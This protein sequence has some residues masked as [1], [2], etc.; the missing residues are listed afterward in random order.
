MIATASCA[1][2]GL[3]NLAS[4]DENLKILHFKANVGS[5][6]LLRGEK[7]ANGVLDF[8]FTGTVL[9]SGAAANAVT[10]TGDVKLEYTNVKYKKQVF[11]GSGHMHLVGE[12]DNVQFFGRSVEGVFNGLG[13]MR[14]YGEFDK[15]LNTGSFW[16]EGG[17]H[18]DWGTSGMT[19][20]VPGMSRNGSAA[21]PFPKPKVK[22]Q[23]KG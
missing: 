7:P 14:L 12:F 16:Y 15:D 10:T 21:V 6:K 4:A 23:G 17:E 20:P 1:L 5:F 11:H 19:L 18:N 8:S 13:I 2:F 22:I 3:A 9:V